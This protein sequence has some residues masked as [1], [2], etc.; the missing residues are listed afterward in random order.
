[1]AAHK[2]V[3]KYDSCNFSSFPADVILG[4]GLFRSLLSHVTTELTGN[5]GERVSAAHHHIGLACSLLTDTDRQGPEVR[6]IGLTFHCL[7]SLQRVSQ[8][9]ELKSRIIMFFGM[10]SNAHPDAE[11]LLVESQELI[12]SIVLYL[13]HLAAGIWH[14]NW[15]IV[16]DPLAATR[17]LLVPPNE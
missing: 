11:A 12:P 1:M 4:W 10:L 15:V 2:I 6:P 8:A 14:K 7:V 9:E 13:C 5:D 3:D 16:D 17:C